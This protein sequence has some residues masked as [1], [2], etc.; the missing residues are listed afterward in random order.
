MKSHQRYLA[1][2]VVPVVLVVIA[3]V[4]PS[5]IYSTVINPLSQVAW[6]IFRG[7][8]AIDQKVY[9][10]ILVVAAVVFAIRI[11]PI[12]REK[13]HPSAYG[14][15]PVT[16]DRLQYWE[17]LIRESETSEESRTAIIRHLMEMRDTIVAGE[18]ASVTASI[19]LPVPRNG[20]LNQLKSTWN[21]ILKAPGKGAETQ[22][23]QEL[24]Q[25]ID[26]IEA[27]LEIKNGNQRHD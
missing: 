27:S 14:D 7:L 4:K 26:S 21:R 8:M 3:L 22:L 2:L 10:G 20:S 16:E 1:F 23:N 18:T 6:L 24:E 19:S 11:A 13:Y 9:W 17:R 12:Q 15:L 5:L 25:M